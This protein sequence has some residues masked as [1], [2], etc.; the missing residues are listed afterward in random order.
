MAKPQPTKKRGMV[1]LVLGIICLLL[2]II[3]NFLP[4]TTLIIWFGIVFVRTV[5]NIVKILTLVLALLFLAFF[6]VVRVK[7]RSTDRARKKAGHLQAETSEGYNPAYVRAEVERSRAVTEGLETELGTALAQ[8]DSMDRKQA[9]ITDIFE[10]N[11]T[12]SLSSVEE[13][14]LNAE[15]SMFGNIIKI[16]NLADLWDDQEYQL[17]AKAGLYEEHRTRIQR[18]LERNDKLLLTTDELLSETIRYLNSRDSG[19]EG[20]V[21]LDSMLETMRSLARMNNAES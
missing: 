3:G 16:I 12:K 13:T 20:S 21:H 10:R 1:F 15:Q 6:V 4:R 9:K 11:Q 17:P 5:L 19:E 14:L 18:L 2:F 7:A 8:M